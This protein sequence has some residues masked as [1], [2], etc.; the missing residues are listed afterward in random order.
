V[1]HPQ[2][3]AFA[4]LANGGA[5]PVRAIAGQNTLFTRT[6][7]D[8]AYDPIHDEILVP[9]FY[10]FGILTFRGD[11]DGDAAPIRKLYG[12]STQIVNNEAVALDPVHGEI[13]V[14]QDRD[15]ILVF[16]RLTDGDAAP[17]RILETSVSRMTIDPVRNLMIVSGGPGIKIF[18][19]MATGKTP[20]LRTIRI[21]D[22]GAGLLT[23]NPD[24]GMIFAVVHGRGG[25]QGE[26]AG[27]FALNDYVGVWNVMDDGPV[28]AR[29]TIGGPNLLLKDG[30]GIAID[31]KSK[32][33][34]VS[35]KTL[36]A[37]LR[38]H[39]PEAF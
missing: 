15:L 14:P 21:E 22:G 1:G 32:D 30:R 38:F 13:F 33:V 5:K 37:V 9:S 39:V 26:L 19:R 34:L 20:P 24:N 18:D 36:N 8:M 6:I 11:A 4:R 25:G 10:L 27:R 17:K 2:I 16:D 7:H 3:A 35:D 29:F 12:P 31:P 23:V 28:P